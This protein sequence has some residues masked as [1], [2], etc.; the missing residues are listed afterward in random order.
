MD[1]DILAEAGAQETSDLQVLYARLDNGEKR[2]RDTAMA[3]LI[4]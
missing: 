2:P 3:L 4:N 1:I